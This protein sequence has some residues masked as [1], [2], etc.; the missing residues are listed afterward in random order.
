M[1]GKENQ[2]EELCS[3][4]TQLTTNNKCNEKENVE[5]NNQSDNQKEH[6]KKHLNCCEEVTPPR[7]MLIITDLPVELIVLVFDYIP[8][9]DKYNASMSCHLLYEAFNHPLLWR[10]QE[11]MV[12]ADHTNFRSK[13]PNRPVYMPEKSKLLIAKFGKYFQFLTIRVCGFIS[14]LKEWGPVLLELGKQ[15]NLQKLVLQVGKMTT[16]LDQRGKPPPEQD[17][18][19]L[20]S[21]IENASRM[22][23]LDIKSWPLFP[24]TI[25]NDNQNIFKALMK[26][27]KLKYLERLD[28]FWPYKSQMW[29]ERM[30]VLPD[31]NVVL[32]LIQHLS[33]LKEL[34]LR[35]AMLSNALINELASSQRIQKLNL[36]KIFVTYA[37]QKAEFQI[38]D[39]NSSSWKQ[40]TDANPAVH[41]EC[42]VMSRV[43]HCELSNMLTLDCPLSKIVFLQWAQIDSPLI[44]SLSSKYNKTLKAF[45]AYCDVKDIDEV[46]IKMVEECQLLDEIF[47]KSTSWYEIH[48]KTI[49]M[50]ASLRGSGWKTFRFDEKNIS[51]LDKPKNIDEDTVIAQNH[52]GE[53]VMVGMQN[54]NAEPQG[55]ERKEKQM[56]LKQKLAKILGPKFVSRMKA[57]I[58][59]RD[60]LLGIQ[61]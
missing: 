50:L 58:I 2:T 11:F 52:K 31:S 5:T 39:L 33:N 4:E 35:S 1:E 45:V 27:Q 37:K 9:C 3:F 17:L 49:L 32:E 29:S 40:L 53:Y 43:P 60:E 34:G 6:E 42:Y 36:L 23:S 61:C 28:L 51:F 44:E 13:Y 57:I 21:F 30:P 54:Y 8:L 59:Y 12:T 24:Q 38:P 56:D 22:K 20:L 19:V 10:I 55:N 41:V 7:S 48:Y 25:L 46:L 18:M 47:I 16:A 14:D 15:C 26:N